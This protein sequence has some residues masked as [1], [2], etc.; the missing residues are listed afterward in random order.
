MA[1]HK[2]RHH[3]SKR[4]LTAHDK[5]VDRRNLSHARSAHEHEAHH[6]YGHPHGHHDKL[7]MHHSKHRPH[8]MEHSEH[9]HHSEHKAHHARHMKHIHNPG[10]DH[11]PNRYNDQERHDKSAH[12]GGMGFNNRIAMAANNNEF[13]AGMD[14]RRRQEIEDA[15]MLH[16]DHRAIANLP[17]EVMIK[18]YPYAYHYLP[19]GLDDTIRGVDDQIGYDDEQRSD[20]FYPKK[21]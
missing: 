8:H 7:P 2:K 11:E 4:H 19:E 9:G 5:A 1:H 15:G 20:H 3:A 21:F 14:A 10:I 17:Q 6:A 13:Y 12:N 18:P 16:E